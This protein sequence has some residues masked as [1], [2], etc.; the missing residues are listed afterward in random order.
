M[1]VS[2]RQVLRGPITPPDIAPDIAS[3]IASVIVAMD[4]WRIA[5]G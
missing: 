4:E 2:G 5:H 3:D 1:V